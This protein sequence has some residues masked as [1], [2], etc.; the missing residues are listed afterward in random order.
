MAKQLAELVPVAI[1]DADRLGHEVLEIAEVKEKLLRR[2]GQSIFDGQGA[3]IR[4]NLAGKV[5]G[6]TPDKLAARTDLEHI[7]HPEI[8]RLALEQIAQHRAAN[9]V[10]WIVL[11]A[12]LLL[13][14]GWRT[15]CDLVVFVEVAPERRAEQVRIQR[16][17]SPEEWRRREASQWPVEQKK[18]AADIV[19]SNNGTLGAA[20]ESLVEALDRWLKPA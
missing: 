5:F 14:A 15:L 9:A 7:T 11:D 20:A 3:V 10:R 17:W 13:E 19:V 4:A 16:G 6:D 8:A 18:A 1:V 2:F 12:A